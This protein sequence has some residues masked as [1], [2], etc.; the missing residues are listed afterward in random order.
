LRNFEQAIATAALAVLPV[1]A[2]ARFGAWFLGPF[3]E[4][5]SLSAIRAAVSELEPAGDYVSS[6]D[7]QACHPEQY[8]SWHASYHRT[9]TQLATPAAVL[10]DFDGVELSESVPAS[11]PG[12]ARE[13]R[14]RLSRRDGA[15]WI[16]QLGGDPSAPVGSARIVMTTGSH[17]QQIYWSSDA[18]N[19]RL[20]MLPWSYLLDEKRWVPRADAFLAPP[21]DPFGVSYWSDVCI[22]CHSTQGRPR[23][24]ERAQ[25]DSTQVTELGIACEMCHGPGGPHVAAN[26][27]PWR[28]YGRP[29]REDPTIVNPERLSARRANE[30]CGRCHSVLSYPKSDRWDGHWNEFRPGD[31][32]VSHGR[33]ILQPE[34]R[35]AAQQRA[36]AEI[37]AAAGGRFV[38]E[39][40]WADGAVRVAGRELAD[41]VSSPCFAGGEFSCLSC[42]SLHDYEN[43][44]D[45]LARGAVG[46]GACLQCH[47]GAG[48]VAANHTRHAPESSGSRCAN[49]HQP[50]TT[51]GLLKAI[52]SHRI[53]SPSVAAELA[54]GR[55][56]AC[57]ACHLDRTLGWTQERLERD[58][59]VPRV[60]LDASAQSVAAAPRWIGIG[61]AGVRAL[62]AGYLGWEPARKAA[63]SDWTAPYLAELL[64]DPYAAVRAVASRSLRTLPAFRD[65]DYDYVG[66]KGSAGDAAR[67][68]VQAQWER[69]AGDPTSPAP[70]P[71]VTSERRLDRESW[72]QLL[73]A[74]DTRPISLSE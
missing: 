38:R 25:T 39:H 2:A 4:Q 34:S 8:R 30:V 36:I 74:R 33:L 73:T 49:C 69:E 46:D 71:L 41:V 19:D 57:N 53:S 14:F 35:D 23:I 48:G 63:G 54:T 59:G 55:P 9:M 72:A 16:T 20:M 50:Y 29:A 32:L 65:L 51:F 62:A 64:A 60:A 21:D 11:A 1:V 58:Y 18:R 56:N 13:D 26:R 67:H 40:F 22:E 66:A 52:R 24:D 42:H 37:E 3:T 68:R 15:Y 44:A 6:R 31:E 12:G 43:R 70:G 7:C 47:A 28:R 45:Q 61:D 17:H 5:R 27:W 10:G